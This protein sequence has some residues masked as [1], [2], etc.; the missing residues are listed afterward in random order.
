M[1]RALDGFLSFDCDDDLA[2][3]IRTEIAL[4]R[5]SGHNLFELNTFDVEF[6][7]AENRVVVGETAS[8]CYE[9]ST[10][11]V[12]DFLAALPDVPAGPG[13]YGR[14]RRVIVLPSPE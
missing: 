14:P 5:G 10:H 2:G 13:M 6:F 4:D 8:F 7:Y 3:R 12:A 11:S 9:T 1:F